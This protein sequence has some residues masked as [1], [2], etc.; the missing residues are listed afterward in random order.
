MTV[1]KEFFMAKDFRDFIE[2]NRSD[3]DDLY[4]KEIY[5][6]GDAEYPE[7]PLFLYSGYSVIMAHLSDGELTLNIYDKDFFVQHIRSGKFSENPDS[8]CSFNFN[9]MSAKLI[10]D[11]VRSIDVWEDGDGA[12]D[13]I[14]LEFSCGKILMIENSDFSDGAMCSYISE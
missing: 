13:K 14:E 9:F 7:S 10:N 1:K 3:S 12:I 8:E 6:T 2:R 11:Y 4:I 5:N